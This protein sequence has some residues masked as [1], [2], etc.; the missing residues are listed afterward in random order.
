MKLEEI[1]ALTRD[2]DKDKMKIEDL[3]KYLSKL[4]FETRKAIEYW[5]KKGEGKKKK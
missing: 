4:Y 3:H 1:M 5:M 2:N